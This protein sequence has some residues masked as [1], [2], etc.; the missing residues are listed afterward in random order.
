[1]DRDVSL[2]GQDPHQ[3]Y[4]PGVTPAALAV[5]NNFVAAMNALKRDLLRSVHYLRVIQE[6]RIH[7]AFGYQN[8]YDYA[9]AAVGF[10]PEQTKALLSLGRNLERYPETKQALAEG[11]LSWSK[12]RLIVAKAHPADERAWLETA[13]GMATGRMRQ[14]LAAA[15]RPQAGGPESAPVA[16]PGLGQPSRAMRPA[17]PELGGRGAALAAA[18]APGPEAEGTEPAAPAPRDLVVSY[19]LTPEQYARWERLAALPGAA[20][21]EERLLTGLAT[22][23][24]GASAGGPEFLLTITECPRCRAAE[25]VT[26]RGRFPVERPLLLAAR[27]DA[28]IQAENG[29]RRA[30]VPPRLRRRVLARDGYACQAPGCRHTQHLQVHHRLPR[31]QGGRT[32]PENLVTLC[33]RCHRELHRREEALREAGRDPCGG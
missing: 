25:L 1:M 32:V 14:E 11:K 26:G 7:R 28:V 16:D 29:T 13:R 17:Q 10:A 19:S 4:P 12:A 21:K 3:P 24:R 15:I 6:R 33:G 22:L 23:G 2:Q 9:R 18:P 30:T 5:H 20:S 8:I 31:A 27:C